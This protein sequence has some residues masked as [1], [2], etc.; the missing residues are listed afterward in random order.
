M[1]PDILNT[2]DTM[3]SKRKVQPV[4][5]KIK[6]KMSMHSPQ[7]TSS[8]RSSNIA[9]TQRPAQPLPPRN[10]PMPNFDNSALQ[11]ARPNNAPLISTGSTKQQEQVKQKL[12]KIPHSKVRYHDLTIFS[13]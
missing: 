13:V 4:Q 6:R 7:S 12:V 2:L 3:D 9:Q 1:V 5:H 11:P 8:P 10:E